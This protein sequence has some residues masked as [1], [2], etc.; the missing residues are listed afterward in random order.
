MQNQTTSPNPRAASQDTAILGTA[1]LL[2][3][4]G[5]S[6]LCLA[7]FV[8]YQ[9]WTQATQAPFVRVVTE[10]LQ[11][12][13]LFELNGVPFKVTG[14]GALVVAFFILLPFVWLAVSMGLSLVRSGVECLLKLKTQ[15]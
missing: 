2:V 10:Q 1:C 15:K 6:V 9:I 13:V 14:E 4:F 7:L 5:L 8:L 12:A 3:A 11:D